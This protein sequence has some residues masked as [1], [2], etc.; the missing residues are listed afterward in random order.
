MGIVLDIGQ[1]IGQFLI[2][3]NTPQPYYEYGMW[4][5]KKDDGSVEV[6]HR[7]FLPD[8]EESTFT[9]KAED[10]LQQ[11][12]WSLFDSTF[13]NCPTF[14]IGSYFLKKKPKSVNLIK[15]IR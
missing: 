9:S 11:K 6:S 3:F 14:R 7:D 13:V 4:N 12:F 2:N 1:Y 5:S 8:D 10:T 15:F